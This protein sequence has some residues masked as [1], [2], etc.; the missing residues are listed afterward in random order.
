MKHIELTNL[1]IDFTNYYIDLHKISKRFKL[2]N[3][4]IVEEFLKHKNMEIPRRNQLDKC[5]P[6]ELAIFTAMQEVEKVG[7]DVKLTQAIQKLQEAKNLVSDFID[8]PERNLHNF[9]CRDCGYGI[10][11]IMDNDKQMLD[12]IRSWITHQHPKF[13]T[14]CSYQLEEVSEKE[15]IQ[16]WRP[17]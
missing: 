17:E 5:I 11:G 1:I 4:T 3:L 8:K 7:S 10:G 15:F 6:A 12:Y 9:I 16:L 13:K 14:R 2:E